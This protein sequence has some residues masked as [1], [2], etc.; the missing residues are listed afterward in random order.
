MLSVG[1]HISDLFDRNNSPILLI[2]EG[3]NGFIDLGNDVL[4]HVVLENGL[5]GSIGDVESSSRWE[6]TSLFIP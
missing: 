4:G 5:I 3:I 6:I 1:C 2:C